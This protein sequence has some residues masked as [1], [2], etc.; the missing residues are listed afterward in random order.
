MMPN[1]LMRTRRCNRVFSKT[2]DVRQGRISLFGIMVGEY[3]NGLVPVVP[4][5]EGLQ[6]G[7]Y[8]EGSHRNAALAVIFLCRNEQ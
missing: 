8:E 1:K 2:R 3:G 7:S 6:L 5:C 4:C